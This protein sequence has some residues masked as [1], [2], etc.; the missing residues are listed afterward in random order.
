MTLVWYYDIKVICG[1]DIVSRIQ[2]VFWV[3]T[4]CDV[5]GCQC[6]KRTLLP[7][8]SGW[9]EWDWEMG[10]DVAASVRGCGVHAGQ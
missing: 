7:L 10:I 4:L 2:V 5:V 1:I 9:S 6:F 8:P 3:V